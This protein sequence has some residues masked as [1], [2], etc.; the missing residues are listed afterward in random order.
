MA[1]VDERRDAPHRVA[2]T[3]NPRRSHAMADD[4]TRTDPDELAD[5]ATTQADERDSH[6]VGRADRMPT[7]EEE[8]RADELELDPEVAEHYREMTATGRDLKGEGRVD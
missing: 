2:G 7:P 5:E 3:R 4:D 6:A 1:P 8:R